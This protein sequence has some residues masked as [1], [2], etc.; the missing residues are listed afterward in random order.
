M[1]QNF[2]VS[3]QEL[4]DNFNV[5]RTTVRAWTKNGLPYIP[6]DQG[7]SHQY[8]P[9]ITMWWR[10]GTMRAEKMYL[11]DLTAAQRIALAREYGEV[12]E[13]HNVDAFV[14][15]LAKV[16]IDENEARS[17]FIFA[18]GIVAGR[19]SA[20]STVQ[21]SRMDVTHTEPQQGA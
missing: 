3:Q 7:K 8:H 13:S 4:A 18:Q 11:P 9:G 21:K 15:Y 2:L 1:S 10:V 19:G 12:D 14:C 17:A 16:G 20:V 6:G 5:N